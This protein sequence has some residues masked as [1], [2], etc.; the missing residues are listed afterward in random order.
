M[1][2]DIFFLLI[3]G[4]RSRDRMVVGFTTAYPIS[5]YHHYNVASSN[6]AH[7]EVYSVQHYVMQFVSD[8]WKVCSFN[9]VLQF[10]PPIKL[11]ATI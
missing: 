3:R 8:L 7:G 6:S 1:Y 2:L 9:R 5:A 4:C 10:H 11:T